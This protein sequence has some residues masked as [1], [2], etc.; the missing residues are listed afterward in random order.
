MI[1]VGGDVGV[2]EHLVAEARA[3]AGT[4]GDAERQLG[5]PS[6]SMSSF[7]LEAAVSVR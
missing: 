3:A 5:S 1:V 4:D 2:E 7:T 6:A